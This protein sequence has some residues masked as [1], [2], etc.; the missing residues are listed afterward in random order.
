[1]RVIDAVDNAKKSETIKCDDYDSSRMNIWGNE[2]MSFFMLKNDLM[3]DLDIFNTEDSQVIRMKDDDEMFEVSLDT[4]KYRPDELSITVGD[5]VISVEGKHEEQSDDGRK[6][7]SRQFSRKYSLPVGAKGDNVLSNLSS[8]GVLVITVNKKDIRGKSVSMSNTESKTCDVATNVHAS[9]F[10][11]NERIPTNLRSNF[12]TDPFFKTNW[13][14]H[15]NVHHKIKGIFSP[16]IKD[17]TEKTSNAVMTNEAKQEEGNQ[18]KMDKKFGKIKEKTTSAALTSEAKQEERNKENITT[19]KM[20]K[21]FGNYRPRRWMLPALSLSS[22]FDTLGSINSDIVSHKEDQ[23]VFEWKIDTSEYEPEEVKVTVSPD[24]ILVEGSHEETSTE[25]KQI[26]SRNFIKKY[27]LP[28]GIKQE[29]VVSKFT[30]DCGLTITAKKNLQNQNH[31]DANNQGIKTEHSITDGQNVNLKEYTSE[32]KEMKNEKKTNGGVKETK[33]KL[34]ENNK[35]HRNVKIEQAKETD[36]KIMSGNFTDNSSDNA[37][38]DEEDFKKPVGVVCGVKMLLSNS[39]DNAKNRNV[40]IEQETKTVSD[41]ATEQ[42]KS[43]LT[44]QEEANKNPVRGAAGVRMHLMSSDKEKTEGIRDIKI[45]KKEE[46]EKSSNDDKENIKSL[47]GA[48]GVRRHLMNSD[49]TSETKESKCKND[50]LIEPEKEK[51]NL[52]EEYKKAFTGSDGVEI[53]IINSG[54]SENKNENGDNINITIEQNTDDDFKIHITD[55]TNGDD[56]VGDSSCGLRKIK[57][58]RDTAAKEMDMKISENEMEMNESQLTKKERNESIV[59]KIQNEKASQNIRIEKE[60]LKKDCEST[61]FEFRNVKIEH[62][63]V[64][65]TES[66]IVTKPVDSQSFLRFS[67]SILIF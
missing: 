31:K 48:G 20:D 57:I 19:T 22:A 65:E 42:S 13:D 53:N 1:M 23:H 34:L 66:D 11:K 54:V 21:K 28:L 8:D 18:G 43:T 26:L 37:T 47:K 64:R 67:F 45:V 51:E 30:P 5:G 59:D 27:S 29:D 62:E 39:S 49:L 35:I 44:N 4:S 9:E 55:V 50:E 52:D 40:K 16:A 38:N 3:K 10:M 41:N 56:D 14:K 12:F 15:E 61:G 58:E 36:M 60:N 2:N 24:C 6:M 46:A 32:D 17:K 7:V 63:T 33:S 25:G